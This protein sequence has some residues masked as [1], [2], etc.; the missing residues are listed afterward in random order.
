MNKKIN[1]VN[2]ITQ[3]ES[4]YYG[5]KIC[6]LSKL[7]DSHIMVCVPEGF[8]LSNLVFIEFLEQNKIKEPINHLLQKIES[9]ETNLELHQKYTEK[10]SHLILNASFDKHITEAIKEKYLLMK[11]KYPNLSF[12]VRSSASGEDSAELSFA[13]Q[14][15]SFLHVNS[16][17]DIIK[18]IKLIFASLYSLESLSYRIKNNIC[19]YSSSMA[20]LIQ[21]MIRSD[22][23]V[24]G[25]MFTRETENNHPEI[26]TINANFGLGESIVQGI[27]NPDEF[28][29]HKKT[30]SIIQKNRGDKKIKT[31]YSKKSTKI[32]KSSRKEQESFALCEEEINKL[33]QL[34]ITIENY[35][36]FKSDIEWAKDY[37]TNKFYILQVR[38]ITYHANTEGELE[39][40]LYEIEEDAAK[41]PLVTGSA[42]GKK[43]AQGNICIIDNIKNIYKIK[44]G[45]ILVTHLTD[46]QWEPAMKVA[47]GIITNAGG[48][49]CHAAII[50]REMGIPAVVGCSNATEKLKNVSYATIAC[51]QGNTGYVYEG[52][53]TIKKTPM[54]KNQHDDLTGFVQNT[55]IMIN[56]GNPNMAFKNAL[57]PSQGVGLARIEFIINNSIGIHPNAII[58]YENM[59]K[60]I[61]K[62]IDKKSIGYKNPLDFYTAKLTEGIATIA[63]AFFPRKVIVRLSDFKTNEYTHLI[64]GQYFEKKE[65]NPMLGLRGAARYLHHDFSAAFDLEIAI[66]RNI[67]NKMNLTNICILV[68][69][70]R[71]VGEAAQMI[72]LLESK[73]ISQKYGT[74]IYMMCE[75]PSNAL[76]ANDFLNYFD[77]FSIGSNDLTQLTLGIDRDGNNNSINTLFDERNQAVKILISLAIESCKKRGKYIGICGQGPSD[78]PDFA[79]WLIEKEIDS[80]SLN[81]DS[82]L[83]FYEGRQ[84]E[85]YT[86]PLP[87]TVPNPIF[88]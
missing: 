27:T 85:K 73:G 5:N 59:P 52:Q 12:A 49:T 43:A 87:N 81:A 58:Q 14:Q 45:D 78:F 21:K 47:S 69:F 15:K 62:I 72:S 41:K 65:E 28:L 42:I 22:K 44:P 76:L 86:I 50:A 1:W 84:K 60:K 48:R 63:A 51:C 6:S 35:F 82:I 37:Y 74:K 18:S 26:I 13:G 46:P 8:A 39:S 80:I 71:T 55:R 38:P 3:I 40:T 7:I 88:I 24:S 25:V 36:G 68:P 53:L 77:G 30:L 29:I 57:I 4:I 70:V 54:K 19:I 32:T 23:S 33:S 11:E 17:S 34:A 64:G 66:L 16:F 31:I 10:I 83:P 75:V 67:I 9:S 20:I 2:Q 61:K 79:S 56:I